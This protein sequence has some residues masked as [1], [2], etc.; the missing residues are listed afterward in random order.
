MGA[1]RGAVDVVV[2]AL[3]HG[4]G[5]SDG[6]TLPDPGG[7]PPSETPIDRVPIAILLGNVAPRRAR[8][9]PPQDAVDDV[10]IILG[11]PATAALPGLA[12]NRQQNPQNTPLDLC[13]IAA[14]QGCLPESA[15][16]NQ[17]GIH[18][19]MILSTLPRACPISMANS[20]INQPTFNYSV[21]YAK[22]FPLFS[23]SMLRLPIL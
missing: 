21:F 15:A 4:L 16:L 20:N 6:D 14:A 12:F 1:N 7:T 19:S 5:E 9:Q 18:A 13:Q 8:A 10:A 2:P 22:T 23:R 11:R 3:G 17:N